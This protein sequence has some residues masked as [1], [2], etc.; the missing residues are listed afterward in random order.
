MGIDAF[1]QISCFIPPL[2]SGPI[3]SL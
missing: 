3:H 2:T 1:H